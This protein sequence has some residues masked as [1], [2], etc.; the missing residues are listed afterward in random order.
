MILPL[1][2][3]NLEVRRRGKRLL[4][5]VTHRFAP[6]GLTAIIGPNGAGKT[7][8]LRALHGLER[9]QG[10][11]RWAVPT[12]EARAAQAFVFQAPTTLRRNLR[13]NIAFPLILNGLP[14]AQAR[15]RAETAAHEVGLG[16]LLDVPASHLSGGECQKMALARALMIAP[17]LLFLDEPCA[18]LDGA[19]TREIE[20][21]LQRAREAGTTILMS[22]HEMGQARRLADHVLFLHRG[23]I[24]EHGPAEAFFDA[25]QTPEAQAHLNGDIVL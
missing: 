17:Q 6:G 10:E 2:V 15:A 3:T 13:D 8:L 5:P 23:R 9:S 19:A 18:S 21:I 7:T 16:A 12:A 11:I 25:P 20:A 22:T 24:L 4:G 14:R 1:T